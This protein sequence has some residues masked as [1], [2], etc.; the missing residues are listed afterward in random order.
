MREHYKFDI[1]KAFIPHQILTEGTENW[2]VYDVNK[3]G[4]SILLGIFRYKKHATWFTERL[5][6]L[7][8][9]R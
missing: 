4:T 2:H 3:D 5:D 7:E 1:I 8:E 9:K 6:A